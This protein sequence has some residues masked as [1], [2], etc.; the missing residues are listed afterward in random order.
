MNARRKCVDHVLS[1]PTL[2]RCMN[3]LCR[4]SE[5]QAASGRGAAERFRLRLK[6]ESCCGKHQIARA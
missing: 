5:P 4:V 6:G 2:T 3:R 1:K